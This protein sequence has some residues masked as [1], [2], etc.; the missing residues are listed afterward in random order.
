M[1]LCYSQI[2]GKV[3]VVLFS[4]DKLLYN[5][6]YYLAIFCYTVAAVHR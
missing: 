4:L 2:D 3:T 6:Y 5:K 1:L